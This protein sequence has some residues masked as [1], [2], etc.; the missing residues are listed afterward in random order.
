MYSRR[1][2]Q[3][4]ILTVLARTNINRRVKPK[5][6]LPDDTTA[7]PTP[8]VILYIYIILHTDER[9]VI[10]GRRYRRRRVDRVPNC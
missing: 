10:A 7:R 9:N 4:L 8:H 3:I 6:V 2:P 1:F 5:T